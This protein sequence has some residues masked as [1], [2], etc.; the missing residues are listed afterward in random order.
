M[1]YD[2]GK[3]LLPL[4]KYREL[5]KV[6]KNYCIIGSYFSDNNKN[7]KYGYGLYDILKQKTL[8]K[9]IFKKVKISPD[10]KYAICTVNFNYPYSQ[11]QIYNIKEEIFSPIFT[12]H[13]ITR[14]PGKKYNNNWYR[15]QVK[16]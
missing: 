5:E 1:N 8:F 12:A 6:N 14:Y 15:Y 9:P 3:F 4:K 11:K 7:T 10:G 16:R 2:N 13:K